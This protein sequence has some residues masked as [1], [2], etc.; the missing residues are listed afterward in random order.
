ML[1]AD[2]RGL[3]ARPTP[4]YSLA[5]PRRMLPPSPPGIRIQ[6]RLQ[7]QQ[8]RDV[9]GHVHHFRQFR[10]RQSAATCWRSFLLT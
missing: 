2:E 5:A 6:R 3:F 7:Q 10:Q 8:R 1:G 4:A 9:A